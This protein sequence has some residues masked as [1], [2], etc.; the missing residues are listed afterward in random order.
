MSQAF[1]FYN[2]HPFYYKGTKAYAYLRTFSSRTFTKRKHAK[3]E[4][5]SVRFTFYSVK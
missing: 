4:T 3:V 2:K 1:G 5:T